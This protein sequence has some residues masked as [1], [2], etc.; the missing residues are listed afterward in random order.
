MSISIGLLSDPHATAE[1]LIEA[2]SLFK[3]KGVDRVLCGGDIAGYG[4]QLDET[5][6]LLQQGSCECVVGNHDLWY[7]E[8]HSAPS[9]LAAHYLQ[10]LPTH[11]ALT[12]EGLSI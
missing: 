4:N 11:L 7:L 3:D 6:R 2:L 5:I 8:R 12:L 1:P 9:P 10:Q